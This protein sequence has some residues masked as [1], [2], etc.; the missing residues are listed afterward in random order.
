MSQGMDKKKPAEGLDVGV[1]KGEI[2]S[3]YHNV[4]NVTWQKVTTE[5]EED[6]TNDKKAEEQRPHC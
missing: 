3:G 5:V 4:Q 2:V 6:N 1:H